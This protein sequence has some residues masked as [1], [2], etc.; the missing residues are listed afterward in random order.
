MGPEVPHRERGRPR[1]HGA[2]ALARTHPAKQRHREGQGRGAVGVVDHEPDERPVGLAT[3]I[4]HTI[5]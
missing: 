3:W 5:G 2:P 4:G 1:M